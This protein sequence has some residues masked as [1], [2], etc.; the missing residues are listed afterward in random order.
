MAHRAFSSSGL[1]F[2]FFCL[3]L[4]YSVCS[5]SN[6]FFMKAV[7]S[8]WWNLRA[9]LSALSSVS[10]MT[11]GVVNSSKNTFN[12]LAGAAYTR[13][14]NASNLL[15]CGTIFSIFRGVAATKLQLYN[16]CILIVC[17]LIKPVHFDSDVPL[18]HTDD[19]ASLHTCFHE[20]QRSCKQQR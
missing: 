20:L 14:I 9:S 2:F 8:R 17:F 7:G 11:A 5:Q 12:R 16:P 3:P 18:S 13:Q 4:W 15:L 6:W 19:R 1:V 10:Y